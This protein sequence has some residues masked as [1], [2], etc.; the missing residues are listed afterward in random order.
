MYKPGYIN[1]HK[2]SDNYTP[3]IIGVHQYTTFKPM[4]TTF[5]FNNYLLG[6]DKVNN[7]VGLSVIKTIFNNI[8]NINKLPSMKTIPLDK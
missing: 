6:S 5:V 3:K 4:L 2:I 1:L 8:D 7:E